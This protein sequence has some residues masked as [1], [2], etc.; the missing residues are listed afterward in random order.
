MNSRYGSASGVESH[1]STRRV[2]TDIQVD[3]RLAA[4]KEDINTFNEI[5]RARRQSEKDRK[6]DT[7]EQ[8]VAAPVAVTTEQTATVG[9]PLANAVSDPFLMTGRQL[10]ETAAATQ[11]LGTQTQGNLSTFAEGVSNQSQSHAALQRIVSVLTRLINTTTEST[12]SG[13][14]RFEVA[15]DAETTI[16]L[17]VQKQGRRDWFVAFSRDD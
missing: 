10:A 7:D 9:Q 13:E 4:K 6:R 3:A 2:P 17:Q 14:W 11:P 8:R 5:M 12:T 16:S 1:R 15:L